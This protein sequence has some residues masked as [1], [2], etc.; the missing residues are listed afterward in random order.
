MV[1]WIYSICPWTLLRHVVGGEL[2]MDQ[3][4]LRF[5]KVEVEYSPQRPDGSLDAPIKAGWDLQANRPYD[6]SA[7]LPPRFMRFCGL[8]YA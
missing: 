8:T 1:I 6:K 2:L 5:T 3:V 7:D 4:S